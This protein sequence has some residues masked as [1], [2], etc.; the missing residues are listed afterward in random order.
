MKKSRKPVT[1]WVVVTDT[2]TILHVASSKRRAQECLRLG[3]SQVYRG[4]GVRVVKV[5]EVGE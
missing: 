1:A 3:V 5:V 2:G 4:L